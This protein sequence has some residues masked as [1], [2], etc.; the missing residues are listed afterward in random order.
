[1]ES[2][3][4]FETTHTTTMKPI[5]YLSILAASRQA[6]SVF[7]PVHG[8]EWVPETTAVTDFTLLNSAS[9]ASTPSSVHWQIPAHGV[10]CSVSS[11]TAIGKPGISTTVPCT[12]SAS[13][14]TAGKFR[15][16]SDEG[17]AALIFVAYAQCAASIYAFYY[18]ADFLVSC[19]MDAG[20]STTCVP[21]GN[22]TAVVTTELYLPR[23]GPPPP[24][25]WW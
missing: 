20:G 2:H 12:A 6:L 4:K 5:I 1:M 23:V 10:E 8:C 24:A 11:T 14:D 13:D 17:D 19:T 25:P 15:V 3:F 9:N 7:V 16:F 22:A 18:R 21:K